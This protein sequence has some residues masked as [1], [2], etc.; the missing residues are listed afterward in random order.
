MS[1]EMDRR[2]ILQDAGAQGAVLDGS[3]CP[4]R[5]IRCI[6]VAGFG[7]EASGNARLELESVQ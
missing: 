2:R 3:R 4:S 5:R 1:E 6:P 7:E